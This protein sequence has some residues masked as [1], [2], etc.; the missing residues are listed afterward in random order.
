MEAVDY[1]E[2]MKSVNLFQ[3]GKAANTIY[4]WSQIL[5]WIGPMAKE[6]IHALLVQAIA[7]SIPCD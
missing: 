3:K 5:K 1:K 2:I 7:T 6:S 4:L